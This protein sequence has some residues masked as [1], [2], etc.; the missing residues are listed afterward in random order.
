MHAGSCIVSSMA[1]RY[2]YRVVLLLRS[3]RLFLD[4][5]RSFVCGSFPF[6]L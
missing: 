3:W 2:V 6:F 5:L 1:F 4:F